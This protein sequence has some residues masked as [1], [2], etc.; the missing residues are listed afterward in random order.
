MQARHNFNSI[1]RTRPQETSRKYIKA[2]NHALEKRRSPKRIMIPG[3][4]TEAA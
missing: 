2:F 3:L 4:S 1:Q